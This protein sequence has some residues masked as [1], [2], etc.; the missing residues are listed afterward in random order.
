MFSVALLTIPQR[1]LL[2]VS[3]S[4]HSAVAFVQNF[5]TF[6][7]VIPPVNFVTT[8]FPLLHQRSLGEVHSSS[9]G[10]RGRC[11]GSRGGGGGGGGGLFR[12]TLLATVRVCFPVTLIL[13]LPA[14][15]RLLPIGRFLTF[16]THRGT[17]LGNLGV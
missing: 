11:C 2:L 16:F 7:L 12:F 9:A 8:F 3:R 15:H 17:F 10:L 1:T 5:L 6:L 4:E 13:T 14:V